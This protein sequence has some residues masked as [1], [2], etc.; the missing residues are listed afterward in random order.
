MNTS[1]AHPTDAEPAT[2]A[3]RSG[4]GATPGLFS[5]LIGR[6]STEDG[7]RIFELL[8]A[9]RAQGLPYEII[10]ADRLNDGVSELVRTRFPEVR[11]LPCSVGT[12]IPELRT[13]ALDLACGEF[14]V[15]TEDHCVPPTD[16]LA[17]LLQAFRDAPVGTVAVGGSVENGVCDTTRDWATFLCEYSAFVA[18]L[19]SGPA[20][21]LPGMNV[22]YRRSALA[23]LDRAV[24]TGGFW[25]TTVHPLLA[26]R[27]AGFYQSCKITILH[28]KKFSF[29]LF[30]NQRYLYSR[31][32]AGLRFPRER[33]AARW[34][35]CGLSMALP[36]V[37]LFRMT[38]SLLA[39]R[40]LIPEFVRALPFLIVFVLIWTWGEMVGYI[41][42]SGD[43]LSRI[44]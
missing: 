5:I 16:W 35:M 18:P 24:L 36:L 28:K 25:E 26:E 17:G 7:T 9:L 32:Y 34:A 12:S 30:A 33:T 4:S 20:A 3:I 22:A 21:S 29:R 43:A 6:V 1:P 19:H 13:L 41:F 11:L 37:L 8:D 44:E 15:V 2:S 40:R 14:V 42:G 38:R 31:Y 39:K 10:I 27:G 23:D